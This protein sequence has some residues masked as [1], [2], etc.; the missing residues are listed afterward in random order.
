MM[1]A[2]ARLHDLLGVLGRLAPSRSS[3][4]PGCP[5]R[6]PPAARGPGPGRSACRTNDTASRSMPCSTAKSTQSR[7]DSPTAAGSASTP[8][9]FMPWCEATVPPVSTFVTDLRVPALAHAQPDRA[10]GEV[11]HVVGLH[12][13]REPGPPDGDRVAAVAVAVRRQRQRP[14][15]C[16]GASRRPRC[17]RAA[18]SARGCRPAARPRGRPSRRPCAPSPRAARGPRCVPWEKLSRSTSAPT[19]IRPLRISGL[20]VA[21]PRVATILVRR[22]ALIM[23]VRATPRGRG[24]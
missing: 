16:A 11:D 10:V 21:G 23:D 24:R 3:R 9:R 17:L 8:G 15:R 5:R 6:A 19:E 4:S 18:A 13:G 7:S 22:M 14:A 12:R 20:W 2:G 1:P